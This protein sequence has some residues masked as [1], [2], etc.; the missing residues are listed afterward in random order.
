MARRNDGALNFWVDGVQRASMTGVDNDT[1]RIDRVRL[2][3]IAG[4]DSGTRGAYFFD[5][6]ESRRSGYIGAAPDASAIAIVADGQTIGATELSL[7]TETTED[8][9]AEATLLQEV[10]QETSIDE[11][12][13]L[14]SGYEVHLPHILP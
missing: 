10:Q 8:D 2:G 14:H 13:H 6:F 12:S 3:A 1:R 7:Y 5:A 11:G 4:I 9:P